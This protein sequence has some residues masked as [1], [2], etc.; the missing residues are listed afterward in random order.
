M[1][2]DVSCRACIF[3]VSRHPDLRR[4]TPEEAIDVNLDLCL[5]AAHTRCLVPTEAGA[6]PKPPPFLDTY[7][8]RALKYAGVSDYSVVSSV[9]VSPTEHVT[10]YAVVMESGER[11]CL[12]FQLAWESIVRA[13]Y[14]GIAT[15][16]AWALKR[17]CGESAVLLVRA[18]SNYASDKG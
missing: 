12:T 6:A 13:A 9:S 16:N 4:R 8:E 10:R 14:R 7:A 18:C 5:Q 1:Y 2:C 3:H 15:E 11:A 17:V